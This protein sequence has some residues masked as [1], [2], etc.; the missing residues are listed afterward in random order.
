[1]RRPFPVPRPLVLGLLLA[2]CPSPWV[3]AL[4]ASP[5]RAHAP[6]DHERL[7]VAPDGKTVRDARGHTL[8]VTLD[9]DLER[10]A[11]L[12]LRRARPD[13]GAIVALDPRNGRILAWS[14]LSPRGS[15]G[16]VVTTAQA[17]AASVFK[18]VTT[19][20]LYERGGVEP[21]REVC[22]SGGMHGIE[23][24][25]LEPA[26]GADALCAPFWEALGHSRN[27]VYAQLSTHLLRDDLTSVAER[28]GFNANVPFDW[29]VPVGRLSV[30]YND[31]EFARAAA[32]F[33]GSTLSPLGG[34]YLASIIAQG[35]VA[36]RL[37]LIDEQPSGGAEP[38]SIVGRV[39]SANTAWRLTRMMEIT[40]H[41]GTA[42]PAF[43]DE[44]KRTL[45]PGVRVAG[46]TGTLKPPGSPL[47]SSWFIGFAPSRHPEIVV[48]VLLQTKDVWRER[49]AEVARDVLRAHFRGRGVPGVADPLL[50]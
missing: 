8:A 30:P 25:H 17:P 14:E 4:A 19:T 49:A 20:A 1:M 36:R 35:G 41:S 32:G 23:R 12:L 9:P 10:A 47:T 3:S 43:S 27:A 29:P 46:K 16:S 11:A 6:I 33:R 48:S 7:T 5:T 13:R 38:A 2:A 22:I 44:R 39:M 45:L 26:R 37:H 18:L 34:A 28:L 21:K 42:R 50:P 24:R 31:L 40:V 15:S